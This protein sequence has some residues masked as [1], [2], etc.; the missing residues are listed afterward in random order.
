MPSAYKWKPLLAGAL[1]HSVNPETIC[2]NE[3]RANLTPLETGFERAWASR[4]NRLKQRRAYARSYP[5]YLELDADVQAEVDQAMVAEENEILE[6]ERWAILKDWQQYYP[7]QFDENGLPLANLPIPIETPTLPG[8]PVAVVNPSPKLQPTVRIKN[9]L[10]RVAKRPRSNMTGSTSFASS[11]MAPPPPSPQA[12]QAS[13]DASRPWASLRQRSCSFRVRG[14]EQIRSITLSILSRAGSLLGSI[15][16]LL[17]A[18]TTIASDSTAGE[19]ISKRTRLGIGQGRRDSS[20]SM[21]Q[22]TRAS[23]SMPTS[24]KDSTF[25]YRLMKEDM[26]GD[27]GM[28]VR[29]EEFDAKSRPLIDWV[30]PVECLMP[31]AEVYEECEE[32]EDVDFVD[33]Y[34]SDEASNG[35]EDSDDEVYSE[36]DGQQEHDEEEEEDD[37]EMGDEVEEPVY[38]SQTFIKSEDGDVNM[39]GMGDPGL[40]GDEAQNRFRASTQEIGEW[41]LGRA[42]TPK[43]FFTCPEEQEDSIEHIVSKRR[44]FLAG[45][46]CLLVDL[47]AATREDAA[48]QGINLE[49]MDKIDCEMDRLAVLNMASQQFRRHIKKGPRD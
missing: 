2:R 4:G 20:A 29:E 13:P 12:P 40:Y 16:V 33:L 48:E 41:L 27:L 11:S 26:E 30:K 21:A 23:L 17:R 34:E 25:E 42:M 14:A 31:N 49:E 18:A 15:T 8:S 9:L 6:Q 19:P 32:D 1:G 36:E 45:N 28:T 3:H 37:D 44:W 38:L 5:D 10:E 47:E 24:G 39:M 35:G 43:D 46:A 22:S 7:N